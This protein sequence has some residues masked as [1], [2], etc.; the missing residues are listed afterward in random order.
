LNVVLLA[1]E[2]AL[3]QTLCGQLDSRQRRYQIRP[4]Q[5]ILAIPPA[6]PS[7][8]VDTRSRY[9]IHT[10]QEKNYSFDDFVRVV[11]MCKQHGHAYFLS[12]DAMVFDGSEGKRFQE[13]DEPKPASVVG[14]SLYLRE[15]YLQLNL[16]H[17]LIIRL[18]LLFSASGHHGVLSL[19]ERFRL[20]QNLP[21]NHFEL[22]CPTHVSDA[23]R[24]ISAALDQLCCDASTWGAFHYCSTDP[25]T[26]Y[27]FAEVILAAASQYWNF[28]SLKLERTDIF[29]PR[30][31]MLHCQKIRD[32]YGIKQV[33]WRAF[34]GETLKSLHASGEV[35]WPRIKS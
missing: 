21:L 3:F 7:I 30:Q 20:S 9:L 13:G 2:G 26:D 16:P 5:D 1:D 19:M 17:H 35:K 11:E 33:P 10:E 28:S 14:K 29:T 8:I 15:R 6:P 31:P 34:V 4:Y 27:E 24:V 12:S 22:H 25:V 23:A 32:T 18:G